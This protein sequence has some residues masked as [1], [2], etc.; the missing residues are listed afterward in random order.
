MREHYG[1][2][3]CL[4]TYAHKLSGRAACSDSPT[5]RGRGEGLVFVQTRVCAIVI[6]NEHTG[7]GNLEVSIRFWG[8]GGTYTPPTGAQNYC[9]KRARRGPW[10]ETL[11]E[12]EIRR[13]FM[14]AGCVGGVCSGL[15]AR[16]DARQE[17]LRFLIYY[18]QTQISALLLLQARPTHSPANNYD[19]DLMLFVVVVVVT[20]CEW[21]THFEGQ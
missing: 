12:P 9:I 5:S 6:D 20:R 7:R 11:H 8:Q 19:A 16:T 18:L 3:V 13:Y 2:T 1:N 14:G 21:T 10:R 4:Y 15:R 17:Q